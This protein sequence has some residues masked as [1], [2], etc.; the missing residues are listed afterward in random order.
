MIEEMQDRGISP[1]TNSNIDREYLTI[2]PHLDE[3]PT[4]EITRY[5]NAISQQRAYVRSTM[6]TFKYMLLPLVQQLKQEKARVFASYPPRMAQAEK[7]LHALEDE[8]YMKVQDSVNKY[9]QRVDYLDS[10]LESLED[11]RFSVSRELSRRTHDF[12][13]E[14]RN[15]RFNA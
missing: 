8:R 10:Y 13:G 3:L 12:E 7:E 6:S 4:S 1:F 2:P 9:Q 15:A 11:L 5:L 14:A